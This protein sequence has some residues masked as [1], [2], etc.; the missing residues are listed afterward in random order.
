MQPAANR[1][2]ATAAQ[3]GACDLVPASKELAIL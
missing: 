3:T 1:V 2:R